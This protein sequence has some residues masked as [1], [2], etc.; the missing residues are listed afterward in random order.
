MLSLAPLNGIIENKG[1]TMSKNKPNNPNNLNYNAIIKYD[2]N[3]QGFARDRKSVGLS[4]QEMADL[5]C[6]ND[7]STIKNIENGEY[8]VEDRTYTLFALI[9]GHHP[10]YVLNGKTAG[11]DLTITPP[12]GETIR[13]TRRSVNGM[14]QR[15]MASLLGLSGHNIISKYEKNIREPSIANWTLFLLIIGKHPH[16]EINLKQEGV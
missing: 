16:Y 1:S 5:L 9:T 15:T 2:G 12:D 8:D 13:Q 3:G 7:V 11:G 6:M 4:Q 10:L 14:T